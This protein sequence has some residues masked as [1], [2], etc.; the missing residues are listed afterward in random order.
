MVGADEIVFKEIRYLGNKVEEEEKDRQLEENYG[1]DKKR[2]QEQAQDDHQISMLFILVSQIN[3]TGE[4]GYK[5]GLR[6]KRAEINKQEQKNTPE[7]NSSVNHLPRE[8]NE[9]DLSEMSENGSS[10]FDSD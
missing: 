2:S 1:D 4:I 6:L 3:L 8:Q 5:G 10:F 7:V 9:L